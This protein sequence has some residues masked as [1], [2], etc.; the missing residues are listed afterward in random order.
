M[1]TATAKFNSERAMVAFYRSDESQPI[2]VSDIPGAFVLEF[3]PETNQA[4]AAGMAAD[5]NAWSYDGRELRQQ[6][7]IVAINPPGERKEIEDA[8]PALL[9]ALRVSG[10]D[11]LTP[12]QRTRIVKLLLGAGTQATEV[13]R[14]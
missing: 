8:R 2:F 3:D 10:W 6:G 9:A 4:V 1:A 13:S 12:V 14:I 5:W 11:G 7:L